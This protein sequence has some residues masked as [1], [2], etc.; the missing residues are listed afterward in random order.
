MS[1]PAAVLPVV[2]AVVAARLAVQRAVG[3]RALRECAADD[4]ERHPAQVAAVD[5][6]GRSQAEVAVQEAEKPA[7]RA[8]PTLTLERLQEARPVLV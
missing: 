8:A 7:R 6:D 4:L 2:G 5:A 3:V 1:T